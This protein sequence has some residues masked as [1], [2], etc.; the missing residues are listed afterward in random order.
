MTSGIE[1]IGALLRMIAE[2]GLTIATPADNPVLVT[3]VQFDGDL[4]TTIYE[5]AATGHPDLK[6]LAKAHSQ[7]IARDLGGLAGLGR[8]LRLTVQWIAIPVPVL[9]FIL[10]G[11]RP[12]FDTF[13]HDWRG[14]CLTAATLALVRYAPGPVIRC[15]IALARRRIKNAIA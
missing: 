5:G 15:M 7:T 11:G 4:V 2:G 8:R 13:L 6:A 1:K 9:L 14:P 12:D 10:G 3:T